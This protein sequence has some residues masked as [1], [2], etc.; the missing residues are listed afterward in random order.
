[1]T[2]NLQMQVASKQIRI[3][4]SVNIAAGIIFHIFDGTIKLLVT[5]YHSVVKSLEQRLDLCQT[6]RPAA[7]SGARAEE[8]GQL[9]AKH[10]LQS[11]GNKLGSCYFYFRGFRYGTDKQ[12]LILFG[13]A[14]AG[15]EWNCR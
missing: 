11:F 13:S 5:E 8:T 1:M 6:L 10:T 12:A 3:A 2:G 7:G 15:A 4:F 9:A 14:E